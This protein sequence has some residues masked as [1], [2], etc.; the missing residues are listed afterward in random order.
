RRKG[1][2]GSDHEQYIATILPFREESTVRELRTK[3][4][5]IE[6]MFAELHQRCV[7]PYLD[8]KLFDQTTIGNFCRYMETRKFSS[9]YRY[10]ILTHLGLLLES[11]SNNVVKELRKFGM[12]PKTPALKPIPWKD[13]GTLR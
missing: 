10:K 6:E 9:E 7:I 12:L 2:L 4:G 5:Y 3:L 13:E 1:L 11:V 8:P